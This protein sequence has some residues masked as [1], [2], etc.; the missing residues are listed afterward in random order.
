MSPDGLRGAEWILAAHPFELGGLPVAWQLSARPHATSVMTEWNAY[1]TTGGPYEA[2]ADLLLAI[3][4]R[5]APD[6][7]FDGPET[8]INA[9]SALGWIRDVDRP[10]T[11]DAKPRD[12]RAPD[13][14]P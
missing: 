12:W 5:E 8:V 6:A 10:R 11:T 3:D 1:F 9:L 14:E 13:P 2:L 7:G 4:A